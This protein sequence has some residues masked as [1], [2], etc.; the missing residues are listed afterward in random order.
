M[1]LWQSQSLSFFDAP[2]ESE[3]NKDGE[4]TVAI[5]NDR[6]TLMTQ[7]NAFI[8]I[9]NTKCQAFKK[10]LQSMKRGEKCRFTVS[11]QFQEENEDEGMAEFF[12]N[13]PAWDKTKAFIMDIEMLKITKVEDWYKEKSTM[14]RTLRKGKGRSPY[15]DSL[16]TFRIK[17]E[18]ND[19]EIFSNY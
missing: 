7:K 2:V 14:M 12:A 5:S 18:V 13:T 16:I 19:T 6:V 8:S 4:Q 9:D 3:E 11:E 15:S 1:R 10:G 17:I